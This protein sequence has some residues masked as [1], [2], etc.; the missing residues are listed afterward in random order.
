MRMRYLIAAT[1]LSLAA[2]SV[3]PDTAFG[4]RR[5]GGGSRGFV[6]V[7]GVGVGWGN[8]YGSYY[9]GYGGYG[10]GWGGYGSG[11]G[12]YGSGWGGYGNYYGNGWGGY[13]GYGRGY[14]NYYGSGYGNYYGSGYYPGSYSYSGYSYPSSN[15][16]YSP[17]Y[18][19]AYP[20]YSAPAMDAGMN[21]AAAR[22][23]DVAINDGAFQPS[24]M[25]VQ[26]G[27]IVRWTNRGQM[28]HTVTSNDGQWSSPDLQPGGTFSLT[29]VHAGTY[30]Y[31]CR[32]HADKMQASITVGSQT[33]M[34][35]D[36]ANRP[37]Q[38]PAPSSNIPE[39]PQ[40]PLPASATTISGEIVRMVG[41][42][43]VILRTPA[44]QE[45]TVYVNPQTTFQLDNRAAAFSDLR[46][47]N[48]I[49]VQ[50]DVRD[51]RFKPI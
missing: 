35:P 2:V 46:A 31:Y 40:E 1:A 22:T 36:V 11:W 7:G 44:G 34:P 49:S 38:L 26:P 39:R 37:A 16:S 51:N 29:F 12:G 18:S 24:K 13:G 43:Q 25:D 45:T 28:V 19:S 21:P 30:N 14:G 33:A 8:G 27:T 4:Q 48:N 3:L 41:Q 42:D 47:G 23:I 10:N 17:S 20:S 9:G 50:Y 32:P 6:Q 15:Y 5:G